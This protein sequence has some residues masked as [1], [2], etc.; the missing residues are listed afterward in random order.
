M[1][2]RFSLGLSDRCKLLVLGRLAEE[3]TIE[4]LLAASW[5]LR[6][7]AIWSEQ[8]CLKSRTII[9]CDLELLSGFDQHRFFHLFSL[10][11]IPLSLERF[12]MY[13]V[14]NVDGATPKR[15][16]IVRFSKGL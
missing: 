12:F 14:V 5:C 16:Q 13:T 6:K 2:F 1:S 11:V 4:R 3:K 7:E 8:C 9:R 15:W 10:L